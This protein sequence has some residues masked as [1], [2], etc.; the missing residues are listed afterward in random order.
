[1]LL[2][3]GA[4]ER[5]QAEQWGGDSPAAASPDGGGDNGGRGGVCRG[6]GRCVK[7]CQ[8]AEGDAFRLAR[9]VQA[10]ATRVA[11]DNNGCFLQVQ[12]LV[13]LTLLFFCVLFVRQKCCVQLIESTVVCTAL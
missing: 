12:P 4:G 3:A 1:M 9:A 13:L 6:D 2:S 5:R 10:G 11:G 8:E 7:E